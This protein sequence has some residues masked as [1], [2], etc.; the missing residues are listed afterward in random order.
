MTFSSFI[1]LNL[2]LGAASL[3]LLLPWHSVAARLPKLIL[4]ICIGMAVAIATINAITSYFGTGRDSN[5]RPVVKGLLEKADKSRPQLLLVG[6]SYSALGVDDSVVEREMNNR[7]YPVQVLELAKPGNFAISQ[8]FTIDYYLAR[9]GKVPEYVFIELGP[10]YYSDP[11]ALGPSYLY[12]GTSIA[13]H[14]LSQFWWRLRSI[15]TYPSD[16]FQKLAKVSNLTTHFLY[17]VFNFGLSGQLVADKDLAPVPGFTPSDKAHKPLE[18]HEL[19]PI[20]NSAAPLSRDPVPP[21]V[22]FLL[23]YRRWQ[24]K[25]LMERGAKVVGYYQVAMVPEGIRVY[26]VQVCRE[27]RELPCFTGD[28]IEVRQQ[29]QDPAFWYDSVHLLHSG[30]EKYS[31]W[32]ASRVADILTASR[33]ASE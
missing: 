29:L 19:S 6:S 27:L 23:D 30:A 25:K 21:H 4:G 3:A 15:L 28:D 11:G 33:L 14:A 24:T 1:I 10:E 2:A 12:T 13:D 9:A 31:V 32:F 8:D 20:E 22:T 16:P 5:I 26:G 18:W 7:G 17:N